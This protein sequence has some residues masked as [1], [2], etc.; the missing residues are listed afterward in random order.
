MVVELIS[1]IISH[2][3]GNN[4][5]EIAVT[6]AG[7]T[8]EGAG[9]EDDAGSDNQGGGAAGIEHRIDA[10]AQHFRNHQTEDGT[11]GKAHESQYPHRPVFLQEIH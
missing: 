9:T 11:G 6:V 10:V 5:G 7:D 3:L 4:L 1:E 2:A 8:P